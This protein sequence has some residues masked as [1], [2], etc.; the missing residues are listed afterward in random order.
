MDKDEETYYDED[1]FIED[2]DDDFTSEEDISSSLEAPNKDTLINSNESS[3]QDGINSDTITEND[4]QNLQD[5]LPNNT[6]QRANNGA[7]AFKRTVNNKNYYNDKSNDIEDKKRD[8]LNNLDK[9]QEKRD[10][11]VNR[12]EQAKSKVNSGNYSKDDKKELRDAKKEI[13]GSNKEGKNLKRENKQL[14]KDKKNVERDSKKANMFKKMHPVQ[15]AKMV[16]EEKVNYLK[17]IVAKKVLIPIALGLFLFV[18]VIEI[19]LGPIMEAFG[20]IDEAITGIANFSEKVENFYNGFGFQ[21]S[22]EAFYDELENLHDRYG[23]NLNIPLLLSTIFYSEGMGYDTKFGETEDTDKDPS[24]TLGSN[25]GLL[26]TAREYF[27]DKYDESRETTEGGLTYNVGKIYR[28]RKLARNQFESDVLGITK[29]TGQERDYFLEDFLEMY[30]KNIASDIVRMF[31]DILAFAFSSI[32]GIFNEIIAKILGSDYQGEYFERLKDITV[33]FEDGMKMLVS[34]TFYTVAAITD[35]SVGLGEEVCVTDENGKK[36]CD[37]KLIS[38]IITCRD[39]KFS[40]ENYNKYLQDYYLESIPEF[41]NMLG[42]LK[43][44]ERENKKKSIIREIYEHEDL[45]RDIYLK[46]NDMPSEEYVENCVGGINNNIISELRSPVDIA[47]GFD[48]RFDGDYSFGIRNGKMHN[49]VDINGASTGNKNGDNVYAIYDGEV[50]ASTPEVSCN[51]RT[52]SSCTSSTGA[53]VKI[54]HTLTK[55]NESYS[56]YSVYMHLQTQ[57]GQPEVGTRVNKG[58]II[59][60][61]GNTGDSSGPHLHFE[62]R[63]DDGTTNGKAVDPTNLFIKCSGISADDWDIHRTTLS[64][65]EFVNKLNN[66]CNSNSCNAGL[67]NFAN[68][69]GL[70]Y[71]TSVKNNVSPELVVVRAIVEGFSPGGTRNNY[72]GIGCT[73]TGGISACHT[74]SSLEEGIKGFANVGPVKN[75]KTASEMMSTYAYIGEYWYNPGSWSV[76]GCAYYPY[77]NGYLT[78]SRTK[79]VGQSCQPSKACKGSRCLKTIDEDQN[80]YARWQVDDK[81]I[82]ERKKIFGY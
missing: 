71:D 10:S 3:K 14:Q 60:K 9:N 63:D 31:K 27:K 81:M 69:A 16:A 5:H 29:R 72:W 22:K 38:I 50:I 40:E 45:F 26:S 54:K 30:G 65:T 80:A 34:D 78:T 33:D 75:S 23:D 43:G 79:I 25:S 15:A 41:R 55:D 18:F 28:L 56:F 8:N 13:R 6:Y 82:S 47:E 73:N 62:F 42:G 46:Y 77:I 19:I 51:M 24:N 17:K 74:Y 7:E 1:D 70:I 36:D 39:Y 20:Y 66:Y 12:L 58:Q 2:L 4:V 11:A 37:R 53:W 48:I 67:K 32:L 52:D 61:I 64:K 57:S 35:V 49:G 59:G 21:N 76:G 44:E 68:N